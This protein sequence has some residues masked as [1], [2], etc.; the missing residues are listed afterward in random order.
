[1]TSDDIRIEL[2]QL[3]I[4]T[5]SNNDEVFKGCLQDIRQLEK[6]F[7]KLKSE[8]DAEVS[9][10]KKQTAQLTNDKIR[11]QQHVIGITARVSAVE[12]D[13]CEKTVAHID[14]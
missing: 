10:I 9:F 5:K 8:D 11:L 13:I 4:N 7:S 1:M 3:E 12:T 2:T 6:M 14:T